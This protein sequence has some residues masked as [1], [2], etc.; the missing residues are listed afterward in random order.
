ML[1]LGRVNK[2]LTG[3][4]R[5]EAK[6]VEAL[7]TLVFH[8]V[9][10]DVL[11]LALGND[12]DIHVAAGALQKVGANK[13]WEERRKGETVRKAVGLVTRVTVRDTLLV[14]THQVVEY[15]G[16]DGIRHQL[17][18]FVQLMGNNTGR[19]ENHT[20]KRNSHDQP[21]AARLTSMS[22]R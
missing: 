14:S 3:S 16:S 4:A 9:R 8:R 20:A 22:L 13:G 15:T 7:A 1:W 17:L 19:S 21:L 6:I 5:L 12:A 2:Q 10:A 11:Y 18:G